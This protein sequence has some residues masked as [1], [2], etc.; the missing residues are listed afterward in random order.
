VRDS[1]HPADNGFHPAYQASHR[2]I[3]GRQSGTYRAPH[4]LVDPRR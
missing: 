4:G 2:A 1:L 3:S